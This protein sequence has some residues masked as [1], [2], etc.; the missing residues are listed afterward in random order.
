MD[1]VNIGI[2]FLKTLF[3]TWKVWYCIQ[4]LAVT[5]VTSYEFNTAMIFFINML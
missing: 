5:S 3:Y 1:F 2:E 4:L